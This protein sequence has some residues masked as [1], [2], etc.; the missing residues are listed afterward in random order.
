[1]PLDA[2]YCSSCGAPAQVAL[3][4]ALAEPST[5]LDPP[6]ETPPLPPQEGEPPSEIPTE[7]RAALEAGDFEQA[8]PGPPVG[9]VPLEEEETF[10]QEAPPDEEE[11]FVQEAPLDEDEAVMQEGPPMDDE[12]LAPPVPKAAENGS[13]EPARGARG[14]LKRRRDG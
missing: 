7:E 12:P 4:P 14:W 11:T 9:D 1:M 10:V 3:G 13:E 6:V 5:P 2:R 8:D